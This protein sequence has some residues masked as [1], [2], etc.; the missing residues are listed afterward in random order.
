VTVAILLVV[1]MFVYVLFFWDDPALRRFERAKREAMEPATPNHAIVK[2]VD[3]H[4]EIG[5]A[6]EETTIV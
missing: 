1:A 5:S 2:P 6:R 3:E 4:P